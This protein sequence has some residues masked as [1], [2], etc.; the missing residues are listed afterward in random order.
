VFANRKSHHSPGSG[1]P[2]PA[3]IRLPQRR[4]P[5]TGSYSLLMSTLPLPWPVRLYF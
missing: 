1:E 5:R 3:P 4:K 2:N